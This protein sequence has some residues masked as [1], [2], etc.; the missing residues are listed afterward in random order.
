M[1]SA[2]ARA[3]PQR[4]RSC[5]SKPSAASAASGAEE[6]HGGCLEECD[7]EGRKLFAHGCLGG[8]DRLAIRRDPCEKVSRASMCVLVPGHP[9]ERPRTSASAAAA[10]LAPGK[11]TSANMN[12][13]SRRRTPRTPATPRTATAP[14]RRARRRRPGARRGSPTSPRSPPRRS[15]LPSSLRAPSPRRATR[16]RV[17]LLR[18]RH[19]LPNSSARSRR[20]AWRCTAPR[21]RQRRARKP[22][23]R[24]QQASGRRRA[25]RPRSPRKEGG[26]SS[27][28]WGRGW[29]GGRTVRR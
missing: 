14:P 17:S 21:G 22:L 8:A 18:A 11:S 25:S 3:H 5:R 2:D 28:R 24:R 27:C 13:A 1:A 29:D 16:S 15:R 7:G 4:A 23:L 19:P 20:S 6:Y 10:D 9:E 26:A 12:E